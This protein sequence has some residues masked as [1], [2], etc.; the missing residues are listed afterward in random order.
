MHELWNTTK[1][2]LAR[3]EKEKADAAEL[4]SRQMSRLKDQLHHLQELLIGKSDKVR[5]LELQV[6]KLTAESGFHREKY[7][8]ERA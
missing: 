4:H 8:A 5:F 2:S 6:D 3:V 7:E 1:R